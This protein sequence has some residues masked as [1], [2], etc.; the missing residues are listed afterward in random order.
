MVLGADDNAG[1]A[2]LPTGGRVAYRSGRR[3]WGDCLKVAACEAASGELNSNRLRE[4]LRRSRGRWRSVLKMITALPS[5]ATMWR[6]FCEKD[7]AFDG[8]FFVAVRTTGIFCRP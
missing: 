4:K 2:R 6:A 8:V 5:T 1:P 3:C 7:P